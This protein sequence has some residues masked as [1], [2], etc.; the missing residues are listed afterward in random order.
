MK[1]VKVGVIG[2][3]YLGQFHA[4]K[5]AALPDV[6]LVG[7]VDTDPVRAAEIA[8]KLNARSFSEPARLLGQVDAVSIVVPTALHHRVAMQFLEQGVHLLLEKPMTVTLEQADELIEMAATKRVILQIGHIERFNP[9]VTSVK[10]LLKSPRYMTAERAAPFTVRCTDVNVVLDLMIH[11]LDI[12]TDLAGSEPKEISAAGASVITKEIDM[13]TARIVFHNGCAADVTASR[14][15]NEKKRLLRVFDEEGVYIS[16]YQTQKA[17]V[18]R[19]GG[20]ALPELVTS[21]ISTERRD[22]L[23]EEITAFVRSIQ[24]GSRPLVSGVEGRRA[25][26]LATRISENINKG[27]KGFDSLE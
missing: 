8:R 23:Y 15:S 18:S 4:E 20:N 10:G 7:V 11:D 3:G 1:R 22:T 24:T 2:V 13:A 6:E 21:D 26:A 25:L 17:S 12:V 19:K 9:A 5:Y 14:I 16:D 27:I